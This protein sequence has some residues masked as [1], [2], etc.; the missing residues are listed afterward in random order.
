MQI[1]ICLI[2]FLC[3]LTLNYSSSYSKDDIIKVLDTYQLPEPK[4][5]EPTFDKTITVNNQID[6]DNMGTNIT[7]SLISGSKN[8]AV[9]IKKGDYFYN[10]NHIKFDHLNYPKS[11]IMIKGNGVRIIA[12]G[13]KVDLYNKEIIESSFLTEDYSPVWLWS[14]LYSVEDTIEVVNEGKRICRLKI[15]NRNIDLNEL[16]NS[17]T[18]KITQWYTSANYKII[19]Y[20]DGYLYFDANDLSFNGNLQRYNVNVDFA[21]GRTPVRFCIFPYIK[22][23]SNIHKIYSCESSR[24]LYIKNSTLSSFTME[25]LSFFGNSPKSDLLELY[26]CKFELCAID[27]CSF[28]S[29]SSTLANIINTNNF[30][31]SNNYVYRCANKGINVTNDC[32]NTYILGNLFENN[33]CSLF[34]NTCIHCSGNDYLISDNIFK[35]FSYSAISLGVWHGTKKNNLSKGVVEYNEIYYDKDYI[36][37]HDQ[38]TLMDGGAI[39]CCTQNDLAIIRY[40]YIHDYWGM[41]DNRGVFCDDGTCNVKI[42]KNVVESIHNSFS[43]DLRLCPN[44]IHQLPVANTGNYIGM[45]YL[46]DPVRFQGMAEDNSN[47]FQ[48]FYVHSGSIINGV[49]IESIKWHLLSKSRIDMIKTITKHINRNNHFL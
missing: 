2:A 13:K 10:E 25:G 4:I 7:E 20:K 36:L 45:N 49:Q 30:L 1:K 6:F 37:H 12:K 43:I 14:S 26:N 32:S 46:T 5:C 18:I 8:I 39:Y 22:K 40:N 38:Y 42:Y 27:N 19:D 3:Y 9:K 44:I 28:N 33:G 21:Y 15:P 23:Y 34:Q 24:F 11:S 48:P 35:N 47:I 41:C 31:F 29:I 17:T 16:Q